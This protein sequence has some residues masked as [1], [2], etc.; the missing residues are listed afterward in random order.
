[1]HYVG[2]LIL[3]PFL[4]ENLFVSS[5]SHFVFLGGLNSIVLEGRPVVSKGSFQLEVKLEVNL[6]STE[7]LTLWG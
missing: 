7:F 4:C 1:V 5:D 6:V 3:T 2:T